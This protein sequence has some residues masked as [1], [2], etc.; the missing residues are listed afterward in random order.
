M[1]YRRILAVGDIHGYFSQFLALYRKLQ[2]SS[3]E[4]LLIF[5]GDY[6]DRGPD[7]LAMLQWVMRKVQEPHVIALRGNH[8]QMMHGYYTMGP[9]GDLWLPNGGRPTYAALCRQELVD[10]HVVRDCLQ[11]IDT[12][13]YSYALEAGGQ[14]Y[15]FCHAGVAPDRPLHKQKPGDLLWIRDW[16]YRGYAGD[17]IVVVGHTPVQ[18]LVPGRTQP[19]FMKEH[20][21]IMTDTGSFLP[22]GRI[23]CVDVLHRKYWQSEAAGPKMV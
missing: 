6:I 23:S 4:D 10:R 17:T 18:Y 8:E 22:G 19:L 5:L 3:S 20:S 13:P 12:L 11:F 1:E 21:I 9:E 7:G 16:F 15:F 14:P 2:F